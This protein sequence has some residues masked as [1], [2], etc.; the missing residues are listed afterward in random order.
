MD[1]VKKRAR[2][3][4]TRRPSIRPLGTVWLAAHNKLAP[5]VVDVSRSGGTRGRPAI[6]HLTYTGSGR[7]WTM[8]GS[9][10]FTHDDL[11]DQLA[12]MANA[13]RRLKGSRDFVRIWLP[14]GDLGCGNSRGWFRRDMSIEVNRAELGALTRLLLAA[15]QQLHTRSSAPRAPARETPER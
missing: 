7:I 8:G 12:A 1:Q 3:P 9:W 13:E 4:A 6:V 5:V 14:T 10:L 15:G 2:R 11:D